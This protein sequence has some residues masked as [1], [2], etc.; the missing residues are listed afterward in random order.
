MRLKLIAIFI[1]IT[2]CN[3]PRNKETR[4]VRLQVAGDSII[5]SEGFT[6]HLVEVDDET[7]LEIE[8]TTPE[9][10]PTETPSPTDTATPPPTETAVP[11]N[12]PTI[13]PTATISATMT[14]CLHD[15][16]EYHG[17][18]GPDCV[19]RH[20]HKHDPNQVNDLFGPPG[21][22]FTAGEISYPHETPNE[23]ANKHEAYSWIVRRD[24]P[25]Y[26][27]A[28]ISDFRLQVHATSA[29]FTAAD[30]TL[31][32]GYLGATH[33]YSLE[34]IY[35]TP[36]GC[37]L[38]VTGGW[39]DYGCL[40]VNGVFVLGED[41][42]LGQ[43]RIHYYYT[44][45][46]SGEL[47]AEF[48]WYGRQNPGAVAPI[49]VAVASADVSVNVDP[50]D[51]FSLHFFCDAINPYD[52][53][54]NDSTIQAHVLQFWP[55]ASYPES[56][57]YYTD[58]YGQ[59]VAGCTAPGLDCIPLVVEGPLWTSAP[60]QYRDDAFGIGSAGTMDFDTAGSIE[61]PN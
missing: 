13:T 48:F 33:S 10:S 38:V 17:D 32:G 50:S 3:T 54:K 7:K 45:D 31:T 43:R 49:I 29:P 44:D 23:N 47:K 5:C 59:L 6:G 36:D 55:K 21:A 22:R 16:T 42:N 30:G 8:C 20:E 9:P 56:G 35:C 24:I 27:D 4:T 51:L 19:Y 61:Y 60:I 34:A 57:G 2:A 40:E 18:T 26:A 28:W 14:F 39:L 1:L 52:C 12:T 15:D 58:R 46:R 37:G 53:N 41:C 25:A 11:T